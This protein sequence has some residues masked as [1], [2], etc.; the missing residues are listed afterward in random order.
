MTDI[1]NAKWLRWPETQA[2]AALFGVELRFVGGCVRDALLGREASEVDA[3]TTLLPE[4]TTALLE[5]GGYRAIPTGLAHGTVTALVG[6]KSFE[7]TTLRR[8]VA[9]DGR[10]AE[11]EYT[12]DW[13]E[14]AAR[15]DFTVNALY[16]D[17]A[18]E[19]FD[20]VGGLADI[21]PLRLRFIGDA[22]ARIAEDA[23]R[24]LRYFRFMAQLGVHDEAA[25]GACRARAGM[26]AELSGERI[27]QEMSKLLGA[28]ALD[29][30]VLESMRRA[31]VLAPLGLPSPPAL[32]LQLMAIERAEKI[33]PSW[34][35][36][37]AAWAEDAKAVAARWK[38]SN[39]DAAVLRI[40]ANASLFAPDMALP[41]QKKQLR[42]LGCEPF[43]DVVLL[44][45][46]KAGGGAAYPAMLALAREWTPPVFPVSGD[47]LLAK[48]YA[49][50]P[51]LGAALKGLEEQWEAGDYRAN[52]EE[53]LAQLPNSQ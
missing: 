33:V 46:A 9:C 28:Q 2:L 48:G 25:L 32:L 1:A 44:S 15:R 36:R 42:R 26:I 19:V 5:K 50:G 47:D 8:D 16:A 7:I 39:A 11:V 45:W 24:I 21:A 18:G 38:L 4:E 14:D 13:A 41:E 10:H 31:E 27:A 17:G 20:Y 52:R 53:L 29:G 43:A 40:L 35:R 37:L 22:E 3:A 23:L 51:K 30:C 6:G 34:L 12:R 49:E